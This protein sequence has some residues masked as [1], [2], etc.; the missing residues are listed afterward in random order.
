MKLFGHPDSGH[1]FKVRFFL[2]AANVAHDYEVVDIWAPRDRRQ[3]E[4]M[5]NARY[6]EVP[7]LLDDG[8]A[9]VQSDAI[10]VHLGRKL[11]AWGMET[12]EREQR[13]LEWLFWEA[14]KIGMCLP[15]LRA[16]RRFE[17]AHLKPAAEEWLRERYNHDV[18]LLNDTLADRRAFLVDDEPTIADFSVCGYLYF[19]E[20]AAV[21][22]PEHVAAWLRRLSERPGFRPPY[23]LMKATG[24]V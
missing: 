19:A 17:T 4:F 24:A 3:P 7:L 5:E 18:G 22:V 21:S 12:P 15:Q 1:A 11:S 13:C 10:L 2:C 8:R 14:N 16:A 9:F 6:H 23:D 20:E